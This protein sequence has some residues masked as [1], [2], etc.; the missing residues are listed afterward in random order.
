MTA[1]RQFVHLHCSAS[2]WIEGMPLVVGGHVLDAVAGS[3]VVITLLE[4]T[5]GS[6]RLGFDGEESMSN[7][8]V[9]S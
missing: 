4:A 9:F 2:K 3:K 1:D 7:D 6:A 8:M 5:G